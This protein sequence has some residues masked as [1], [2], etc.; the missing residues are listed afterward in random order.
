MNNGLR[1]CF[2]VTGAAW[3]ARIISISIN[4]FILFT[5]LS[6]LGTDSYAIAA[7]VLSLKGW[8]AL[9]DFGLGLSLQNYLSESLAKNEETKELFKTAF[10]LA[11]VIL[12]FLLLAT[13]FMSHT[14]DEVLFTK[15]ANNN[16]DV[17]LLISTSYIVFSIGSI[18]YKV[19]YALQKGYMA[20]LFQ[21]FSDILCG[22]G[23]LTV[24]TYYTGQSKLFFSL[25]PLTG[26]PA[27][28]TI[29]VFFCFFCSKVSISSLFSSFSLEYCKKIIVR[30]FSFW[31]IALMAA[32]ILLIDYIVAARTLINTD[33]VQ[34]NISEK[35]LSAI[36]FAY[37][38]VLISLHPKFTEMHTKGLHQEMHL[39][40]KKTCLIGCILL[41]ALTFICFAFINSFATH[42]VNESLFYSKYTLFLMSF[43]L[44]LRI[45]TDTFAIAIQSTSK[46][47]AFFI[48]VPI[49]ILLNFPLQYYCSLKFGLNGI[50]IGLTSSFLLT[51][52]WA[53]PWEYYK[54]HK[55]SK[56]IHA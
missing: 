15:I 26:I 11:V 40:I 19:F 30:G 14:L 5:L 41:P 29:T 52:A 16:Y 20:H 39:I 1:I 49:Q 56:Y 46:T 23:V 12:S 10:Q 6:F 37:N 3:A 24:K 31:L 28:V 34:Y 47:K 21:I 48:Y 9:A 35:G 4:F 53:M 7:I 25:L 8:F 2:Q 36:F 33:I 55:R 51:V 38:S 17:F 44:L 13:A 45:I 42:I 27:L 50:Y 43:Y 32:S 18:V 54:I 22:I